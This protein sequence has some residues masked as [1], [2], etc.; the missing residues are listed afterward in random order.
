M[1]QHREMKLSSRL[2]T[3]A[4]AGF[5]GTMAMTAAMRRLHAR[6]PAKERYPLTPREIVD[7]VAEAAGTKLSTD[8]AK[9]LTTAAHF[10]YG[11]AIGALIA[12]ANPEPSRKTGAAA[13]LAVW[14][15]SYMGWIPAVNVLEP[16]TRHPARRNLLMIGVHLVWGAATASAMRELKLA[17]ETILADGPNRDVPSGGLDRRRAGA[18][19]MPLPLSRR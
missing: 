14:L 12:A 7:S 18:R 2:V 5:V 17:R 10:A 11:A 1:T 13:G 15:A 3:G 19:A 9:D 8:A 6:L 16:A 4:I